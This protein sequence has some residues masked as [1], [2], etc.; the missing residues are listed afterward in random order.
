MKMTITKEFDF[1][2]AHH[3]TK[4]Y[5]KCERVHG[6]TYK[7]L[8]TVT[9]DLGE[10]DMIIDFI[11][12]KRVVK[13]HILEHLDHNDLNTILDNP[14]TENLALWIWDKLK[15]LDQLLLEE[16]DDPN[17]DSEIKKYLTEQ[18]GTLDKSQ[19]HAKIKLTEI[20]LY[21]SATSHVTLTAT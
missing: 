4:Y 10:N 7:L 3:V 15:N 16:L 1:D 21:E 13:K 20:K 9:G 5:G 12:L 17:L 8:V 19:Q 2:A 6:H 14:T 11:I 18:T